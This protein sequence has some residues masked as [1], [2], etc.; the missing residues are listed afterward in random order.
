MTDTAALNVAVFGASGNIGRHVVDQLL[1][2]GH[3][4][5]AYVRNPGKLGVTHPNLRIIQGELTDAATIAR[6]VDGADAVI[7]ALGPT[8]KHSATGTPVTEGARHI[9]QAMQAAGV[10]ATSAWPPLRSPTSETNPRSRRRSCAR[11]PA[12]LPQRARRD[13][14]HDGRGPELWPRLD[15]CPHHQP[16]R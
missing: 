5:T 4:V 12:C 14:W 9:V 6:A 11:C 16:K 7:N 1:A 13:H 3:N 2:A 15:H 10:A 8:L